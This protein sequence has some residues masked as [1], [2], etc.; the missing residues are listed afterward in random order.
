[1]CLWCVQYLRRSVRQTEA[2]SKKMKMQSW[3]G[4]LTIVL[5]EGCDLV[6]MD[7]NGLSDP[8]VKFRL[9]NEKYRSKVGVWR[10]L[11]FF[12]QLLAW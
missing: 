3:S 11:C 6:P 10:R 5:V 4:V 1:M 2:T 8:Y 7:D 9:G 12:V